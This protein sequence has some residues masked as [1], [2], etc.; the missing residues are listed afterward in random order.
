MSAPPPAPLPQAIGNAP[1]QSQPANTSQ[2][3]INRAA[4][5]ARAHAAGIEEVS[6]NKDCSESEGSNPGRDW[7]TYESVYNHVKVECYN[8]SWSNSESDG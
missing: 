7:L 5:R 4:A 3:L 6:K 2:E 8:M 1:L